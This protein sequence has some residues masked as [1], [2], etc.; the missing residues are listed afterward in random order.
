MVLPRLI[1]AVYGN[2][3]DLPIPNHPLL[4]ASLTV[5]LGAI[6]GALSRYYLTILFSQW[7]GTGF[8]F[9]TFFINLS[10]ALFIGFFATWGLENSLS[11]NLLTLVITGFL[12]SYTTFSTYTLDTSVL[13]R[14]G[15]LTRAIFYWVGSIVLGGVCLELGI[16]LAKMVGQLRA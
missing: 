9:G 6:P 2:I 15:S 13:L 12:G 11:P 5:C 3:A 8:P 10:G 14:G 4:Q 7:L 16:I 1:L